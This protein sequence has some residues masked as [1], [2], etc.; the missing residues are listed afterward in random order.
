MNDNLDPWMQRLNSIHM[1]RKKAL[2]YRAMSLPQNHLRFAQPRRI[3]SAADHEW[4]PHHALTQRNAHGKCSVAP[5]ML[6]RK[7][8]DLLI[9]RQRPLESRR[10]IGRRAHQPATLAAKSFDRRR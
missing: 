8:Q 5:E 7:K 4:V 6:V 9:A 2:V 1:L 3:N 10:R